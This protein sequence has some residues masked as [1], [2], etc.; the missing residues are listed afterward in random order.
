VCDIKCIGGCG[1]K[2]PMEPSLIIENGNYKPTWF[3]MYRNNKLI[4]AVCRKCYD[5]G[6]VLMD[7]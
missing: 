2:L 7:Q 3:G 4:K 6:H 1:M 5:N